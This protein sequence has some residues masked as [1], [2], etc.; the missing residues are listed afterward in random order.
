V[1][2]LRLSLLSLSV[3]DL[4]NDGGVVRD[5]REDT[6]DEDGVGGREEVDP[7]LTEVSQSWVEEGGQGGCGACW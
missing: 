5:D 4:C 3:E 7:G 2:G 1:S 6:G